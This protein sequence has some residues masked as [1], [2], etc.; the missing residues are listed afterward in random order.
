MNSTTDPA[1]R[2]IRIA[3]TLNDRGE[4]AL[5]FQASYDTECKKRP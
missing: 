1:V 3:S 4:E 2:S 5:A